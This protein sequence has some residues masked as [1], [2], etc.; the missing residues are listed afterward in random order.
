ME[1]KRYNQA[2]VNYQPSEMFKME[3]DQREENRTELKELNRLFY[4]QE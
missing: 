1:K 2:Y 3:N 4:R